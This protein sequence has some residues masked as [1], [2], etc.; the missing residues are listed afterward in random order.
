MRPIREWLDH[1]T[2]LETAIRQFLY[3]EIPASSGWHQVFGSVAVFLFLTQAFTGALLAFNYAPTPGDA[4]NSLR[5]ILTE[6]TGGRLIRGLHHWGASMMIVVV[7]LHMVQTF[8][9]GA[10]K[11]PREATWMV[12][13]VLLLV[14]MAYGL[15]GYLLPWDNR[16]YWG[17][18]VTTRIAGGAP[19]LGPYILRLMGGGGAVGVVTFARFYGL[20]VLLLPPATLLLIAVHVYLVRK[21]GVAPAPGDEALPKQQFYPRQVFKDTVAIFAAFA[22]LF[23]MAV[24]IRVPLEQLAD[25]TDTTYNPR[26]E[27]YFLFLFQFLRLLPGSLEVFGSVVLPGLAVMTLILVPFID[28]TRMVKVTKRTFAFSVAFL[29]LAGWTGLTI[30]A[31]K[32][33]PKD[34][35]V[36]VDYSAPTDWMQLSPEEMAGVAYFRQ[37]N[38]ISCH[39]IGERGNSVGPDLTRT[40]IHKD[41]AWMIQHF[42]RP[43]AMRPGSSMPPIQLNDQQLNSLAAFLL[44]LNADN[45]TALSNAPDFATQGALVYQANH[46]GSCHAVNGVGMKVGPPLNGLA[47]RQTRSWVEDHFANPQK[48]SPGSFMPPYKLSPKDMES[49]TTYL[50]ALPE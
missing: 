48:L 10:Y 25:P 2:G 20:H 42:K 30:A 43:A 8:L 34:A 41:A 12:G 9:Y 31:V 16:A 37:E 21:H 28:R 38:C 11:K 19:F 1:R 33:T 15:T 23:L 47:K 26:P 4:Y 29:G 50:F 27:W 13:V 44:K 3:E 46:C 5:Y 22:I 45:A 6:V 14:T 40:T 7:V 18:V 39:A 24:A 49:L 36:A 32:T 35:E 17:T